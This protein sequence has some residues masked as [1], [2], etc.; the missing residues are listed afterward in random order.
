MHIGE[1]QVLKVN[2]MECNPCTHN[3]YSMQTHWMLP[4]LH[5]V[6][7]VITIWYSFATIISVLTILNKSSK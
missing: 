1:L 5:T 4:S 7:Q 2:A 6:F 3:D